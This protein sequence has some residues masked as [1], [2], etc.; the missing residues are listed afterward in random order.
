MFVDFKTA[1]DRIIRKLLRG[2]MAEFGFP[3]KLIALAKLT[4][5]N[6]KARVRIRNNLSEIFETM[7]ATVFGKTEK[8]AFWDLTTND[9][10]S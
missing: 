9:R 2:I 10:R 3:A 5:L 6:V 4:L 7:D 8:S 1:Y